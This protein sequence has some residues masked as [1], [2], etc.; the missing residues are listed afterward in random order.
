MQ[1]DKNVSIYCMPEI[2]P[3]DDENI[4]DGIMKQIYLI[5]IIELFETQICEGE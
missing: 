2:Q 4:F 3:F 1:V 5:Y